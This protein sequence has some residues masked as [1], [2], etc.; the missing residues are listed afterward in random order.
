MGSGTGTVASQHAAPPGPAHGPRSQGR[1]APCPPLSDPKEG[2]Q[3]LPFRP[4]SI[5]FINKDNGWC[6][7]F[8]DSK[9]FPN[10]LG[11]VAQVLLNEFRADHSQEGGRGLVRHC[12]G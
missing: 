3:S 8:S 12:F 2:R 4:N 9:Q 6:V 5:N 10:E 1:A 7:F 11:A